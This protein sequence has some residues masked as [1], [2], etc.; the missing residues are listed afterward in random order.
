M[1]SYKKTA[2][3]I[4][5]SHTILLPTGAYDIE[6]INQEIIERIEGITGKN[7]IS[8]P[9]EPDKYPIEIHAKEPLLGTSIEINDPKY[10]VD[11]YH[12]SIRSLLGWP[13]YIPDTDAIADIPPEPQRSDHDSDES[14]SQARKTWMDNLPIIHP[15][16]PEPVQS[17]F[18]TDSVPVPEIQL[19]YSDDGL[20]RVLKTASD[21]NPRIRII[22]NEQSSEWITDG[23]V[24][25]RLSSLSSG[26][27]YTITYKKLSEKFVNIK[28]VF[29]T[30]L[31]QL[32]DLF[33]RGLS[34]A[35]I[36]RG[37]N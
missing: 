25:W 27:E 35:T 7:R 1:F 31:Q 28:K 3:A 8:I 17:D 16:T 6:D 4:P 23:P 24:T 10:S 18:I 36:T 5:E 13:E 22:T 15:R 37:G 14:F 2:D 26:R 32:Q 12:S 29:Q 33:Q 30:H 11:I 34:G 21:I 20:L 9:D 19:D